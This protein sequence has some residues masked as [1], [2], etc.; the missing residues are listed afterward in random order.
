MT[1]LCSQESNAL[2]SL[3]QALDNIRQSITPI[4]GT[5]RV[6]LKNALNRIAAQNVHSPINIPLERNSAMDG[7][8]LNSRDITPS[9]SFSL[10]QVG[11]S[12]AG[13]PFQGELNPGECIRIFTGGVVPESA[14]SVI[15]QEQA[16]AKGNTIQ[17]P[18]KITP[19]NNIRQAGD[20]IQQGDC[21]IKRGKKIAAADMALL[22]SA[23]VYD[24]G[25]RRKIRIGYFSTGDELI[26]IG[27]QPGSGCIYDSNRY[28]LHALLSNP[29]HSIADLGVIKDDKQLLQQAFCQ[30]AQQFDVIISTGGASVGDADYVQEI[31]HSI[32]RVNFWK[33]AIKPGKPLAFGRIGN[34]YFFGLP[35]NPVSVIATFQQIVAPALEQLSGN[36]TTQAIRISAI[37]TDRLKKQPGRQEF[38]RGILNQSADGQFQVQSA[39]KQGSHI[40]SAASQA[41]CYI[42]LPAQSSGVNPGESVWVE[43]FDSR[44]A[45]L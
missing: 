43:P 40:L 18:A 12:W 3:Q 44:L 24:I 15:M 1:D 2:I 6:I 29:N 5:E 13:K 30:A 16:S 28:A 26:P 45:A 35:G 17:F 38:Q 27:Q 8:A 41:N 20:D 25:V 22:A 19:F 10:K 39:G 42:I 9:E 23:G 7:Y 36:Q 4:K 37:C 14:D 34:S 32:G 31:L 21:L 33:I 11:T